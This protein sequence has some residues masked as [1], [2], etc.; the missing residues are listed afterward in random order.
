MLCC[1]GRGVKRVD[2][3][4]PHALHKGITFCIRD[5]RIPHQLP[6]YMPLRFREH[7]VHAWAM[8]AI[9]L[10]RGDVM[11][12]SLVAMLSDTLRTEDCGFSLHVGS[13]PMGLAASDA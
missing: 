2:T 9:R 11:A 13:V 4:E 8:G 6:I 7:S 12:S 5:K 3:L 10:H 1:G